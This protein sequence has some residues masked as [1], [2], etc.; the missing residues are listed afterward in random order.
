MTIS[1]LNCLRYKSCLRGGTLLFT[2]PTDFITCKMCVM[3][4]TTYWL[5]IAEGNPVELHLL[6][7]PN[8]AAVKIH[9]NPCQVLFAS[10]FSVQPSRHSGI[11]RTR[12]GT[13]RQ[14]WW[15]FI[16]ANEASK[17]S[18]VITP[19]F[20]RLSSQE[21]LLFSTLVFDPPAVRKEHTSLTPLHYPPL[22]LYS[23]LCPCFFLILLQPT[24]HFSVSSFNQ[25]TL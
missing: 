24:L 6:L 7:L 22:L 19:R 12:S 16:A 3:K 18:S 4:R 23:R 14:M 2:G 5:V 11:L 17:I 9:L 13:D 8:A 10:Y 15:V 1:F 25:S 21:K 20:L